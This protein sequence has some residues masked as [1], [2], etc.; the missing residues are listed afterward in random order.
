MGR[1][2]ASQP[3][4]LPGPREAETLFKK[5]GGPSH[6]WTPQIPGGPVARLSPYLPSAAGA[7]HHLPRARTR[8]CQAADL[9]NRAAEGSPSD[10]GRARTPGVLSFLTSLRPTLPFQGFFFFFGRC[11][12]RFHFIALC[13]RSRTRSRE[14]PPS[15]GP[16]EGAARGR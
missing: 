9:Q 16:R 15:P 4:P 3:R 10:C 8:P 5:G 6:L 13:L 11:A 7:A 14:T 2:A 12:S 1:L